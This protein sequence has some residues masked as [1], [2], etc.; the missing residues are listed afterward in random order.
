M[1]TLSKSAGND[2]E[3]QY[4]EEIRQVFHERTFYIGSVAS[5]L[6]LF[7]AILDYYLLPE[8]FREFLLF[9]L[10]VSAVLLVLVY[11]NYRDARLQYAI[12][13]P[14]LGYFVVLIALGL[15]I[16]R[17][18][19]VESNYFVGFIQIVVIYSAIIPL[20]M[21]QALV[22]GFLG[23]SV[24]LISVL[25]AGS[26]MEDTGLTMFNNLF[27]MVG[28]VLMALVCSWQEEKT[29]RESFSLRIQE[30]K[31]ADLCHERATVLEDEVARRSAEYQRSEN[32]Y[33]TLF[34]HISDDIVIV[35]KK[36]IIEHAYPPFLRK[37]GLNKEDNEDGKNNLV[38]LVVYGEQVRLKRDLLAEIAKK[39][40]VDSFQTRLYKSD[41]DIIV[42]EINGNT[43]K[44]PGKKAAVQLVIRDIS[45]RKQME[46]DVRK[47]LQVRKQ[48]ENAAIMALARLSEFR[49]IT[50]NNHLERIREYSRL[51]AIGLATHP[52]CR[53]DLSGSAVMDVAMASVL[54]DIGKVA[55]P[56]AVLFKSGPLTDEEMNVVKKH[57]VFG[58]DVIKAMESPEETSSFLLYAKS[59]A[60]FHHEKWDGSGYPFAL[61]GDEIPMAARIVA[62]ADTYETLTASCTLADCCSHKK[63]LHAIIKGSG[64]HFDPLVVDVFLNLEQEFS[65]VLENW[66]MG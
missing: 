10:T 37:F 44:Q 34:E 61:S 33:R 11:F 7:F 40:V 28:F 57:T 31:A 49:D 46:E 38:D 39:G 56:D 65:G 23:I 9:R 63:A 14:P 13:I 25:I 41:D 45:M 59:I 42:V 29:R 55:I 64:V 52:N 36:G 21:V 35:S 30:K 27:F 5:F 66:G 4:Q 8:L 62:L 16:V 20:T 24:Y 18:G 17:M 2:F 22:S 43:F 26:V 32:R 6:F 19:G 54:H 60:Y 53:E 50:P 15:M 47:S 58:G 12:L 1:N 51:L 3:D 48:T